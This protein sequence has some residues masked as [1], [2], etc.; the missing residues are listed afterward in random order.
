VVIFVFRTIWALCTAVAALHLWHI[1]CQSE[2]LIYAYLGG[3]LCISVAMAIVAVAVVRVSA[4]GCIMERQKRAPLNGLLHVLVALNILEVAWTTFGIYALIGRFFNLCN[5]SEGQ[6]APGLII[7]GNIV[8]AI[9]YGLLVLFT[10]MCWHDRTSHIVEL[11]EGEEYHATRHRTISRI[12]TQLCCCTSVG[13]SS[14]SSVDPYEEVSALLI[15][16]LSEEIADIAPS[17][18]VAA[19]ILLRRDHALQYDE[20]DMPGEDVVDINDH[21]SVHDIL[22]AGYYVKYAVAS[23][24]WPVYLYTH[25]SSGLCSLLNYTSKAFCGCCKRESKCR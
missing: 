15:S 12:I 1:R 7:S 4:K 3:S 9:I 10:V 21:A 13:K 23:Y 11:Q 5:L 20:V 18:I 16:L 6:L 8:I 2:R 17:D 25:L 24:G 19:L 14:G 22:E